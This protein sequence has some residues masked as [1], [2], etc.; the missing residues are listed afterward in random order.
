MTTCCAWVTPCTIRV[1]IVL[2]LEL[3]CIG[4]GEK[5]LE[6]C[7]RVVEILCPASPGTDLAERP[8]QHHCEILT[9]STME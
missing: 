4:P 8:L 2:S 7:A 5:V 9:A 6:N 3:R 1:E